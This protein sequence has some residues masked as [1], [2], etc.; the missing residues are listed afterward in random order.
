[1]TKNKI[2]YGNPPEAT[3]FKKGISANPKGRPRKSDMMLGDLVDRALQSKTHYTE[4]G[5]PLSASRLR[6]VIRAHTMKA[7][8]GDVGSALTLLKMR[9]QALK[10]EDYGDTIRIHFVGGMQ[11]SRKLQKK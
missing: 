8:D 11:P 2:G 5:L 3:K 7:L 1:M 10:N 9:E 6:F 4:R